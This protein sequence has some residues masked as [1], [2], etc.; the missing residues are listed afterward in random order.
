MTRCTWWG[1]RRVSAGGPVSRQQPADADFPDGEGVEQGILPRSGLQ[2]LDAL[3]GC[4]V[5]QA[6]LPGF[7]RGPSEENQPGALRRVV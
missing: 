7:G 3:A 2:C 6:D 4:L 1:T 5:E